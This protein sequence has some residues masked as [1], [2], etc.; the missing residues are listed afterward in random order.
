MM[1]LS[2]ANVD[3]V[4]KDC[5]FE[6]EELI[7]DPIIVQAITTTFGLDKVK[8]KKHTD[9]ITLML[10]QLP[11]AFKSSGG[12]GMSFLNA[13]ENSDGEQ[14]TGM[15]Q[16]MEQLFALGLACEKVKLLMPREY[17]PALP[18]GMPYYVVLD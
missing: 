3:M 14:W 16:V 18:G 13:C 4:F 2:A 5:L 7:L 1:K 8:V 10:S 17:W 6:S 12:G 15:H 9:D 11:D